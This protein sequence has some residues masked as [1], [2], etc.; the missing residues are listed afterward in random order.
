M[1]S[2]KVNNRVVE[3]DKDCKLL[4]F[5]RD[6]LHLKGTK[7]GCSE[8]ACGTCTVIIN[9]KAVKAC[10]KRTSSLKGASIITI[11]GLTEREQQVYS[12]CFAVAGAVQCG[13]CTPAMIMSAKALLDMNNNPSPDQI[14][15]A[16]KHNICRCT[17]LCKD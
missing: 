12:H 5:L 8:G 15:K 7:D 11:E 16:I 4:R 3:T 14:R 2:F 6:E 9:G 13:Y 1:Y 10:T 17:G